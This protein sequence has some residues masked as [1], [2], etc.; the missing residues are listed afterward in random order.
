MRHFSVLS[1]VFSVRNALLFSVQE[2]KSTDTEHAGNRCFPN[3]NQKQKIQRGLCFAVQSPR[4]THRSICDGCLLRHGRLLCGFIFLCGFFRFGSF[5]SLCGFRSLR[6]FLCLGCTRCRCLGY[7]V[8]LVN[9]LLVSVR[10]LDTEVGTGLIRFLPGGQ[11]IRNTVD[12][13]VCSPVRNIIHFADQN[14]I[15]NTGTLA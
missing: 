3:P 15:V 8:V 11:I 4:F 13:L 5:R 7:L 6:G 12:N 1:R 2:R 14:H 9:L 10:Q